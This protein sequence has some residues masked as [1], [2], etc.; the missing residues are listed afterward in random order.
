MVSILNGS[1]RVGIGGTCSNNLNFGSNSRVSSA[2]KQVWRN[3]YGIEN[4]LSRVIGSVGENADIPLTSSIRTIGN[5]D[6]CA[7][8]KNLLESG[9][10]AAC[11]TAASWA[12]GLSSRSGK[13]DGFRLV[14]ETDRKRIL[15]AGAKYVSQTPVTITAFPAK[16]SAGGLHDF[17]S[18]ADHFWPNPKDA[19]GPYINRD[20][21]SNP[22]NFDE[23]RKVML[24]L[25]I[26]VPALTAAWLLTGE[27]PYGK[28]ACA[29][30]RL[31]RLPRNADESEPAVLSSGSRVFNGPL[32]R[33][34]R[35]VALTDG[36]A[37][38]QTVAG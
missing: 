32:L 14:G 34:H 6:K 8:E 19:N 4:C 36:R 2:V 30:P 17:Y 1:K 15:E 20:G 25:S 18:Q 12:F 33:H 3:H 21:Q 11:M 24:A 9:G 16:R 22:E 35:R 7:R 23:H 37:G 29:P 13:S 28:K 5:A 26:Q 27:R 10:S 31:V 38:C